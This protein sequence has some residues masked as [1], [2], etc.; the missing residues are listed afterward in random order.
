MPMLRTALFEDNHIHSTYSDGKLTIAEILEY[1]ALHNRLD[2]TISDH[3][4]MKTGWFPA[5]AKEITE[6]RRKYRDF[7]VRI[8][9]EV[10]ILENG[11]LNTTREILDAAETVIGSVH[12]FTGIKAMD[13]GELL[14]KE[15][16]LTKMLARHPDVDVLGHP[17]SMCKR[18]YNLDAPKEYV[19]DVY[20]MC[21]KNGVKFEFN[22]KQSL[23][24][25]HT[26]VSDEIAKGNIHHFSFGS[27]LHELAEELG[28]AAFAL[29]APITVLVTGAGA[30]VGQSIL[31]ALKLS[32]VRTRIIAVDMDPLAAGL[33]RADAA[34]VIPAAKDPRYI[35]TLRKICM[36]EHVELLLIG[37]D[38]ELEIL[39]RS[40]DEFEKETGAKIIVSHPDTIAIADDK[41]KTAEFLESHDLPFVRSALPD[42]VDDL[43]RDAGFPLAVKPRVGARSVG[44][45]IVKDEKSLRTLLKTMKNAVVQEYLRDD[46][47]EYTCGG[48]FY[49]G[50]CYGVISMQRWLRSGD[51]YK[52]IARRDPKMEKF[53]EEVGKKL[54]ITG[55]CNFQLR[56]S[57][58]T[59][60][61]FEINCRFSG[62]TGAASALGFNVVNVL[63]QKIFFDRPLRR[64]SFRESYIFRYWNEVLAPVAQAEAMMRG[65]AE[66][67]QSFLNVF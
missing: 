2:L 49:E 63:L 23:G 15:Y 53:I 18:F 35:E 55:P 31:K 21:V 52:A 7:Q 62:T 44:F 67:P 59:F 29:V 43:I 24:S 17:F 20:A 25:I 13:K 56:K 50:E 40:R 1:N 47:G 37:T 61:I 5:Y 26:F 38:V 34:H 41:W 42:S 66:K 58:G 10:K 6:L 27:D 48:F 11:T 16:E 60:K 64:L 39:A 22:D 14:E 9:C 8:G 33:Y 12:H 28:D 30:G 32:N 51:T 4:N 36:A 45:Q 46:D 54:K 3:V 65:H 19:E 57:G